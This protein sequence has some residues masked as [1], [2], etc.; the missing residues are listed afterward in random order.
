M[1]HVV[2]AAT[3]K[4]PRIGCRFTIWHRGILPGE[5]L[6]RLDLRPARTAAEADFTGGER[7][8]IGDNPFIFLRH[9]KKVR[10]TADLLAH[11]PAERGAHGGLAA[12]KSLGFREP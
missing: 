9:S 1:L 6:D 8:W 5:E 11:D 3:A 12:A 2:R 7:G 4:M 10:A